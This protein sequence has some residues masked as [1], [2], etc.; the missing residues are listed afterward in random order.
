MR[1]VCV[2]RADLALPPS[3]SSSHGSLTQYLSQCDDDQ[4]RAIGGSY[5]ELSKSDSLRQEPP[6]T[7]CIRQHVRTFRAGIRAARKGISWPRTDSPVVTAQLAGI[8][9]PSLSTLASKDVSRH[10][11]SDAHSLPD[12]I[13]L[14]RSKASLSQLA[15]RGKLPSRQPVLPQKVR[16]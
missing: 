13:L 5:A 14:P 3:M 11:S 12:N 7:E 6:R 4:S 15:I 10:T 16:R 1:A 8:E 2:P 9:T